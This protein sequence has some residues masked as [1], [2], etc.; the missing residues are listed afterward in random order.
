MSD[1]PVPRLLGLYRD[2][3]DEDGTPATWVPIGWAVELP[4]R[5][6]ITIPLEGPIGVSIWQDLDDA[7]KTLDAYVDEISPR[8]RPSLRQSRDAGARDRSAG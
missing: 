8:R 7:K 3:F 2:G 1:P 6:A 4:G 5:G